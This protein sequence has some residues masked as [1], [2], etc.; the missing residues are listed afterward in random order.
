MARL[1]A[2]RG[3]K[4]SVQMLLDKKAKQQASRSLMSFDLDPRCWCQGLY[5]LNL[6]LTPLHSYTT[7]GSKGG[8]RLC[9]RSGGWQPRRAGA[10]GRE[11]GETK[12]SPRS[13]SPSPLTGLYNAKPPTLPSCHKPRHS[14][15]SSTPCYLLASLTKRRPFP[16]I[17]LR[18]ENLPTPPLDGRQRAR[19]DAQGMEARTFWP[20]Q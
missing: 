15:P 6:T 17:A 13:A 3:R 8:R 1:E 4:I 18:S 11:R 2:S 7:T 14:R 5:C 19:T 12:K 20:R 10:R 9:R 16:T